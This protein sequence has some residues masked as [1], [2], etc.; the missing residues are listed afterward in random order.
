MRKSQKSVASLRLIIGENIRLERSRLG[1][2]QEALAEKAKLHRNYV[3]AIER[4][5]VSVG[6]DHVEILADALGLKPFELL[7]ALKREGS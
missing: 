3:G 5:E 7:Q 6:V 4:A 2:S 1:L